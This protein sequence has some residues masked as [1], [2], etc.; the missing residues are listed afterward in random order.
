MKL[1]LGLFLIHQCVSWAG[2]QIGCRCKWEPINLTYLSL[3][4]RI[5]FGI[6]FPETV[7]GHVDN[8]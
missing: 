3:Q 8:G 5:A 4:A 1:G 6:T 7:Q 2:E